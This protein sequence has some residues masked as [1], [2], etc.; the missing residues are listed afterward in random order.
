MDE[1]LFQ[2]RE[3]AF[4]GCIIPAVSFAAHG[5]SD[6]VLFENPLVMIAGVLHASIGMCDQ[7]FSRKLPVD[8]HLQRVRHQSTV[9]S[10]RH[11]P[12]HDLPGIQILM[13][14][15]MFRQNGGNYGDSWFPLIIL[16]CL[17]IGAIVWFNWHQMIES[18]EATKQDLQLAKSKLQE[19]ESRKE[20][21]R[22]AKRQ[23]KEA[24]REKRRKSRERREAREYADELELVEW[25]EKSI[26]Q[27][28]TE[29]PVPTEQIAVFE[30][31]VG[32]FRKAEAERLK[33][34]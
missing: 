1:F 9:N 19:I 25:Y 17:F 2:C 33:T 12:A 23:E 34:S 22:D 18:H 27:M 7:T 24:L 13:R 8:G 15:E 21:R 20:S 6:P 10:L 3:E 4:H 30:E 32:K 29:S 11:R 5:T 31:Y 26:E 16:V 14:D 28:K